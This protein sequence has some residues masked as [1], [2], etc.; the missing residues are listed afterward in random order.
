VLVLAAPVR[1]G[2]GGNHGIEKGEGRTDS[3]EEKGQEEQDSPEWSPWHLCDGVGQGVESECVCADRVAFTGFHVQETD[4]TKD[5]KC[6][7]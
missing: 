7:K 4:N 5:C 3:K 1:V 2:D 6:C